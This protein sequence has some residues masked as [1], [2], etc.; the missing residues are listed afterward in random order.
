[1]IKFEPKIGQTSIKARDLDR[2]FARVQPIQNGQYGINQTEEGWSL[3]IFPPF[4]EIATEALALTY[5]G[6]A[7]QWRSLGQLVDESEGGDG[8]GTIGGGPQVPDVEELVVQTYEPSLTPEEPAV[9]GYKTLVDLLDTLTDEQKLTIINNWLAQ[10]AA[11]DGGIGVREIERCDGQ[12]MKVLGTVW[13]S[14]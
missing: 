8:G 3:N 5:T 11:D 10:I 14:P 2:N 7:M 13:Y 12:R 1:M 6:G 9:D 4:P